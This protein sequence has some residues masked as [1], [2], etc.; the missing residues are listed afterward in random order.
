MKLALIVLV[1]TLAAV[2]ARNVAYPYADR[3]TWPDFQSPSTNFNSEEEEEEMADRMFNDHGYQYRPSMQA[4]S[5]LTPCMQNIIMYVSLFGRCT[6][7]K[8]ASL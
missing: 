7:R 6:G 4:D 1:A 8:C 5:E 3:R 2:S